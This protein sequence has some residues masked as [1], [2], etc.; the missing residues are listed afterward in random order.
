MGEL[1]NYLNKELLML[2]HFRYG[3]LF[4][5][6]CKNAYISFVTPELLELVKAKWNQAVEKISCYNITR[7]STD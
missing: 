7:A 6:R 3:D 2:E 5:R 1:S 4:L